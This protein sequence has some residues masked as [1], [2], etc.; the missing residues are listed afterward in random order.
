M[1]DFKP[2]YKQYDPYILKVQSNIRNSNIIKIN[3][4]RIN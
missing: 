1:F 2:E 4:N 3:V